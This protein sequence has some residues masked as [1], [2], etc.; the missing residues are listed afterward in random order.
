MKIIAC[1]IRVSMVES[2]Q[3]KQRR[4]INRWLKSNRF[5]PK[6]VRWYVDKS[7]KNLHQPKLEKLTADILEG[8]VRTVVVWHFDRL[9][10]TPWDGLRGLVDWCDK[11]IRI[12]SVSQRIDIKS[13]DCSLIGS[14]LRGV[15]EMDKRTRGERTKLGLAV[16]RAR[17]REGGRPPVAPDDAK[18]IQAKKLAKDVSLSIDD[19]CERLKISRSTYYRYVAM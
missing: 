5:S 7:S 15:A 13:A 11:S 3:A 9:A 19:I 18:V 6:T 17:G 12:V 10:L 8:K 2:D 16:A 14:V 1:Y 4:E